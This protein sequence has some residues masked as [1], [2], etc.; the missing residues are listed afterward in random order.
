MKKVYLSSA[1]ALL[2]ATSLFTTSCIGSFT[3]T[4][5]VLAWNQNVGDKFVNELVF[6]ALVILPVYEIATV[7]DAVILNTI[8]F[9]GGDPIIASSTRNVKGQNGD[10]YLVKCDAT[11][12]TITNETA[13]TTMRL[14]YDKNE[15]TWSVNTGSEV[16]PLMSFVDDN[17]VNMYLPDGS[18]KLVELSEAGTL[19]FQQVASGM[20]TAQR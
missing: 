19:A 7:A 3:L 10:D 8:E 16:Y 17:H 2:L 18:M 9:W 12:Y 20:Y 13:G 5:K 6:L 11:G 1:V 15:Q 14:D 4:R